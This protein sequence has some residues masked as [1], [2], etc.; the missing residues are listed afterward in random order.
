MYALKPTE[1]IAPAIGRAWFFII[2]VFFN[3]GIGFSRY[4]C[5]S[6]LLKLWNHILHKLVSLDLHH[7]QWNCMGYLHRIV[8]FFCNWKHAPSHWQDMFFTNFNKFHCFLKVWY[9][10]FKIAIFSKFLKNCNPSK[11]RL[12]TQ[13]NDG[14]LDFF[15]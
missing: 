7:F 4:R 11:K 8:L 6:K 3:C 12:S 1:N 13:R 10:F 14:V 5:F 9:R 2:I 15:Y